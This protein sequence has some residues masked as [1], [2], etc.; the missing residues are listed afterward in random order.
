M[1]FCQNCFVQNIGG[2][3]LSKPFGESFLKIII[4]MV[5]HVFL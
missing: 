1:R 4:L 3:F 5:L 2:M